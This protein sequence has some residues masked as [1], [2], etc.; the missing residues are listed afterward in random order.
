MRVC[1]ST[2]DVQV[3]KN[4]TWN[5]STVRQR[6]LTL[7]L[8]FSVRKNGLFHVTQHNALNETIDCV[9]VQ[10]ITTL[11]TVT[12]H[13]QQNQNSGMLLQ[14]SV[15]MCVIEASST[16]SPR[17]WWRER[18]SCRSNVSLTGTGIVQSCNGRIL[19]VVFN[20]ELLITYSAD[21]RP[22][23]LAAK[24]SFCVAKLSCRYKRY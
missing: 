8:K 13:H 20:R 1:T 22:D 6:R 16:P 19:K 11:Q 23:A 5:S 7:K 15:T 10:S 17:A 3:F 18:N 21:L 14:E 9:P 12:L 24:K 2:C 4:I